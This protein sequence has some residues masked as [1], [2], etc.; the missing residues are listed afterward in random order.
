MPKLAKKYSRKSN[1]FYRK[2]TPSVIEDTTTTERP[3]STTAMQDITIPNGA[4]SSHLMIQA[5]ST[6]KLRTDLIS[7]VIAIMTL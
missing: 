5:T 1:G 3:G 6:L 7:I 4:D 2:L